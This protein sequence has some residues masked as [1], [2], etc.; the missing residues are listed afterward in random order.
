VSGLTWQKTYDSQK[1]WQ[2]ALA[3][4]ESLS[5]GGYS[6]WRLPSKKELLSLV[7][8]GVAS[9]VS[10]FPEMPAALPGPSPSLW[11]WTS[12]TS[13]GATSFAW[14]VDFYSGYVF[15]TNKPDVAYT[16]CVRLGP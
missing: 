4:C 11:F 3:Y 6:N 2:Q 5:Y 12:S 1:T 8:F 10:D 9:P 13:V 15:N 16:R 7:N 14:Y